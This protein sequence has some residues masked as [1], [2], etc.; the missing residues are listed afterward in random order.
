MSQLCT[1][2]CKDEVLRSLA[3]ELD[4]AEACILCGREKR[5]SIDLTD[6]RTKETFRALLRFHFHER[7]YNG[8]LGG[9]DF[10]FLLSRD[11]PL[12][13]HSRREGVDDLCVEV[14]ENGYETEDVGVSL[15]AGYWNQQQLP[16]LESL[17]DA[18]AE[19]LTRARK[20]LFYKNHFEIAPLIRQ[21]LE[22]LR[23]YVS[24]EVRGRSFARA[25]IGFSA[26][27][28]NF[29]TG[30]VDY[31]PFSS[32]DLMAPPPPIATTGRL[33][34]QGVSFLYVTDDV[35]TALAEVRP[36]PGHIVSVGRIEL[37]RP[38]V[39]ADFTSIALS[40]FSSSDENLDN[41]VFLRSIERDFSTPVVPEERSSYLLGQLVA[42]LL[43]DLGFDGV[44]YHSAV[45]A[46]RNYCFFEPERLRYIPKTGEVFQ[47]RS[48]HYET[49]PLVPVTDLPKSKY[50]NRK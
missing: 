42:D 11:N 23:G 21:R 29:E 36:H 6:R 47:V 15:F 44:A 35:Q 37:S 41:F 24:S 14:I 26:S 22:K 18:E 16:P 2:C 32:G 1:Q 12:V 30:E 10:F 34:R 38:S 8:H 9:D 5:F 19:A 31:V 33:N 3:L 17:R 46:G 20:E 45:A 39:I 7:E 25:R 4:P 48:L 49:Q 13:D 28:T 50:F 27:G 43:R 40:S